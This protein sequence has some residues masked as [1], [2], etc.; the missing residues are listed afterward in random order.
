MSG[1]PPS[2]S[3]PAGPGVGR[4]LFR[5]TLVSGAASLVT[6]VVTLA[7][8]PFHIDRLGGEAYG[9]WVLVASFSLSTGYLSLADLGLQQALVKFV[10]QS[11]GRETARADVDRYV[12]SSTAL[13]GAMAV[14][15]GVAT[16]LLA[17]VSPALFN[18]PDDLTGPLRVLLLVLGVEALVGLPALAYLGLLEGLER[19]VVIRAIEVGRLLL[20]A[21]GTV[22]V[23]LRGDGLVAFGLV[24]VGA[25]LAAHV[26]YVV[27]ARLV[28]G[29]VRARPERAALVELRGF[30]GWLFLSKL[31]GTAWRQMDKTILA[32]VAAT[33]VLTVYDIANKVQAAAA[34]IL[35]FTGSALLPAVAGPGAAGDLDLLREMLLRGTRYTLA[36]SLPV[37]AGAMAITPELLEGWGGPEFVAAAPA[38]RLFLSYQLFVSSATVALS[39]LIGVG[40]VRRTAT[41]GSF[42]LLLNLAISLALAPR[43][44]VSG[45]VLATVVAYGVTTVLYLRLAMA[46]LELAWGRFVAETVGRIGPWAAL[47]AALLWFVVQAL[48]PTTL[49]GIAALAT[50]IGLL[51]VAGVAFVAFS[52]AERRSLLRYV[53][54]R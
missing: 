40:R 29:P 17:W 54:R 48:D 44:G 43:W 46:E 35:S 11:R 31:T 51:Y 25:S 12:R 21:A 8:V 42:A 30:G 39:I 9:V 24:A 4:E 52:P 18:V 27:A 49:V 33:G 45:V 53:R 32:L 6:L 37:V 13:F 1:P 50:P 38:T 23:L 2:G 47:F 28:W 7:L 15:A 22:A 5:N 19:F 20:Y 26:A 41:Y 36:L 10:A 34:A 3:L 16:A 14:V